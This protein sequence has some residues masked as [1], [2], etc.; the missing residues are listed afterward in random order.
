MDFK[1]MGTSDIMGFLNSVCHSGKQNDYPVLYS[2]ALQELTRQSPLLAMPYQS[3]T[4]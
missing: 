3:K 2:E 1:K 4:V